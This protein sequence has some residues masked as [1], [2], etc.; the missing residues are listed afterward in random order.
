MLSPATAATN[1]ITATSTMFSRP[2]PAYTAAATSTA[3]PG[4]GMPKL[5]SS[6]RLPT[7]L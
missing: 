6:S 7:A 3:S 5:S 1:A 4:T 2:A